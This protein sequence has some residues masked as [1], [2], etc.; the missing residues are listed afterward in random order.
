MIAPPRPFSRTRLY[1]AWAVSRKNSAADRCGSMFADQLLLV[2]AGAFALM[3]YRWPTL[4]RPR[5]GLPPALASLEKF[6]H[7]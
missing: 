3:G 2:L 5:A 4:V 1:A 7:H 6:Q